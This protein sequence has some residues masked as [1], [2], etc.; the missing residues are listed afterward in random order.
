ML[1]AGLLS[2][3]L[4]LSENNGEIFQISK[5][6]SKRSVCSNKIIYFATEDGKDL[7]IEDYDDIPTDEAVDICGENFVSVI[8]APDHSGI[9]VARNEDIIGSGGNISLKDASGTYHLALKNDLPDSDIVIFTFDNAFIDA[10]SKRLMATEVFASE[11][12][13]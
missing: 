8:I 3:S 1:G 9:L 5:I 2:K 10:N 11:W 7:I 4:V 6:N 13:Y 12:N